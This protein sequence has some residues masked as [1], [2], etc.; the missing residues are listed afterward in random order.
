MKYAVDYRSMHT[1]LHGLIIFNKRSTAD[2]VLSGLKR[3]DFSADF[4]DAVEYAFE[5]ADG[6][7]PEVD[8]RTLEE[9]MKGVE[10]NDNN[11]LT[12]STVT[13]NVRIINFNQSVDI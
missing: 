2:M 12:V 3:D 5:I 9:V 1:A 13:S 8:Y 4:E 10:F 11:S 7:I 6:V